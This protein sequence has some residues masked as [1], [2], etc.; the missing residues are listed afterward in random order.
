MNV[1]PAGNSVVV[2]GNP[3]S[4]SVEDFKVGTQYKQQWFLQSNNLKQFCLLLS[5]LLD[6]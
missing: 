6:C 3:L 4:R 5:S 2:L 1:G